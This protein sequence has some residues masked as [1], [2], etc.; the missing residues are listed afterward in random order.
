MPTIPV[1][2]GFTLGDWMPP[3]AL[4]SIAGTS[5]AWRSSIAADGV[6][7]LISEFR[8]KPR[9]K[10]LLWGLL[11]AVQDAEDAKW[12]VLTGI[13]LDTAEGVQLDGLGVLLDLERAGWSDD[14]YRAYLKAKILVLRSDASG[15]ALIAI[16]SAIGVTLELATLERSG[17]AAIRLTLDE[18]LD[19]EI[20]PADVF[21][22]L[23]HAT[24]AGVRF[25]LEF[26]TVE[27]TDAFTW[28]DGDVDQADTRRGWPTDDS[29]F[30]DG[31]YWNGELAT[32]EAA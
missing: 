4:A 21:A 23:S 12:Q 18:L 31:G 32:T 14:T 28:A 20:E 7:R 11:A 3:P 6:A 19:E 30:V 10:A 22:M 2:L 26:P 16:L 8:G 27:L 17:M 15:P 24:A 1:E 29:A 25:T 5:L 9:I 13:W